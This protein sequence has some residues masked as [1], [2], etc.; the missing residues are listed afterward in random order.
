MV[1]R[2]QCVGVVTMA[3]SHFYGRE[4]GKGGGAPVYTRILVYFCVVS[5][6]SNTIKIKG[7]TEKRNNGIWINSNVLC[8]YCVHRVAVACMLVH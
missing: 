3:V 2:G 8:K 1:E 7:L 6:R 5:V 4:N